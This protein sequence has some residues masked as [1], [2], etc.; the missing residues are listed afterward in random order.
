VTAVP[1]D[2]RLRLLLL[3]LSGNMLI[4]ALEVSTVVV[5]MP[6]IAA[7]FAVGPA[8]GGAVLAAFALGFGCAILPAGRLTA[9]FGRRRCYLWATAVFA[10][11]SVLGGLAV[12]L[13]LL[14]LTRVV[15]GVCVALTAPTGLA[16]IA[17]T[18][19]PG[20]ARDR[21]LSVY[22]LV[23]A[24]G[25]SVGL[26]LSGAL[27]SIDWRWALA[28]S[29]LVAFALLLPARSVIPAGQDG[30]VEPVG[31]GPAPSWS[32]RSL[33]RAVIGGAVLNGTFWGFLLL[34]TFQWQ[35]QRSWSPW[36]VALLLLPT[37]VLLV[38]AAR[39]GGPLSA[40]VGRAR[41]IVAGGASAVL[42]YGWYL[43]DGAAVA[44]TVVLIG[45][46]YALSFSA[47]N[48]EAVAD[49]PPA[50]RRLVGGVFQT[51][52]QLGGAAMIALVAL[53]RVEPRPAITL[54]TAVAAGGLLVN[55]ALLVAA[56]RSGT[57]RDDPASGNLREER[58]ARQ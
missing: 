10:V 15:K 57:G 51:A 34:V 24:G 58:H 31:P 18:F 56:P 48:A 11:T 33:W 30:P 17:G 42:G 27:T 50:R 41:L 40:R 20:A 13:P 7:E 38:I 55:V 3:V 16:I 12:S 36:T 6:A 49:A 47:L 26:M 39:Y 54:I 32:S 9:R 19:A 29:G 53:T 52:V 44:P 14:L 28:Y 25:F 21:A 35:Q 8:A 5:A 46:A 23:G 45:V 22:T 37:S 1:T 43:A 2:R 4:D